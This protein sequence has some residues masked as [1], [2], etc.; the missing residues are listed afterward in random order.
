MALFHPGNT[1]FDAFNKLFHTKNYSKDE[2]VLGYL[3]IVE[4]NKSWHK[5]VRLNPIQAGGSESMYSLDAP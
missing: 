5:M 4:N 1:F 3:D 2:T